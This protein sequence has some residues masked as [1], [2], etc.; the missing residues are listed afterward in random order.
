MTSPEPR[1]AAGEAGE[2]TD[3]VAHPGLVAVHGRGI[4]VPV[5]GSEGHGHQPC[6]V[7][8]GNLVEPEA[9]LVDQHAV[10]EA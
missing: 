2:R 6:R 8:R 3:G 5:A 10:V 7:G 4:K 9:Q 1:S